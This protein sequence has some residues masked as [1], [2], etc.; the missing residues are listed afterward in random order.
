MRNEK[1]HL[2]K[3]DQTSNTHHSGDGSD[4]R[5]DSESTDDEDEEEYNE[6]HEDHTPLNNQDIYF[7]NSTDTEKPI[8]PTTTDDEHSQLIFLFYYF[9]FKF[10]FLIF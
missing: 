10:Y 9:N 4:H 8:S 2:N 6:N 1:P 5:V 7:A 3:P